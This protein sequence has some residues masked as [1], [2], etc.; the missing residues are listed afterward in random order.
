[1]QQGGRDFGEGLQDE[2]AF[3]HGR[4]GQGKVGVGEDKAAARLSR[5]LVFGVEEQVKIKQAGTFR[6][7]TGVPDATHGGFK[8]EECPHEFKGAEAGFEQCGGVGKA[9]L[10][11]KTYRLGFVE[12]GGGDEGAQIGESAQGLAEG[13]GGRP[14]AGREVRAEGDGG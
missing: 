8:G 9:W 2:P 5:R 3:V 4:V 1:M 12:V 10:V 7:L 11:E 14:V 13:V 6:G